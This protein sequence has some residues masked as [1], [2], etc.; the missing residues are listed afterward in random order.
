MTLDTRIVAT[1]VCD[2]RDAFYE[3]RRLLGAGDDVRVEDEPVNDESYYGK[4]VRCISHP[5]GSGLNAWLMVH[6]RPNLEPRRTPEESR[7]CDADCD[8]GCDGTGWSH[9]T[10]CWVEMS[11][12]TAYGYHGPEGG[13]GA[14]HA[15]LVYELGQWFDERKIGWGWQNEFTGDW[16]YEDKYYALKEL[17]DG[18]GKA[19]AWFTE[20]VI[21]TI[22]AT[23]A[24]FV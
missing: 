10:A 13:C 12:D 16:H 24:R 20:T 17:V 6:Y 4:G 11:I 19:M 15:R 1:T 21:P 3:M 5:P 7:Q 22:E 18:G 23:G 2:G 14:L 9:R 8:P